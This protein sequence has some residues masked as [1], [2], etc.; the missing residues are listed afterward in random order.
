MIG[1]I[2]VIKNNCNNKVYIG[3][4][5]TSLK[6]RW[7]EHVRESKKDDYILY[8]AMRKYGIENFYMEQL[9]V[10]DVE[11]LDE[12]EI[13]YIKYFNSTDDRFGYNMSLGGKTPKFKQE[14]IDENLVINLYCNEKKN[15]S[16]ISKLIGISRYRITNVLKQHNITIRD[17]HESNK[18]FDKLNK[19]TILSALDKNKSLR[20]A[21]K[22]LGVTY[23]TF[24]NACVYHNIEYNSTTS[25]RHQETDEDVC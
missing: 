9:D 20:S 13:S 25:V 11:M 12:L 6:Q 5:R 15:L 3:Q 4:T 21:A 16:E 22:C 17:R 2:Y 24:R 18:R 10:C 19:S 8:R 23:S 14:K 7:N 1:Y